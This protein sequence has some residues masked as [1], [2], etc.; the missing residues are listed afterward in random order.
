VLRTY[1]PGSERILEL[2]TR[3]N[4]SRIFAIAPLFERDIFAIASWPGEVV[5]ASLGWQ[6]LVTIS[7]PILMWALAVGVAYFAV[8][9]LALR[10]ILYLDRLVTAYGKSGRA[11]RAQRM[12]D[13]PTEIAKLGV[14]FDEMAEEIETRESALLETVEEKEILLR[15]VNHRVKNNLQLISSLLNLQIRDSGG[16]REKLGLE[17]LQERI[18]GLALVHQKIYESEKMNA[19]RLDRLI[20]EIAGN[21]RDGSARTLDSVK[22]TTALEPVMVAPDVA[23]PLVLFATEAIVNAFKHSLSFA[24][25]GDLDITLK[26]EGEHVRLGVTNSLHPGGC[27]AEDGRRGIGQQLIDGFARQ[28]RGEI[29]RTRTDETF[30]IDLLI[31]TEKVIASQPKAAVS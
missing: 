23:V 27:E 18:Q 9:Q 5:P 7:L 31:P 15:E 29:S 1:L 28:L 17:R 24:E 10:H 11:L 12:R 13:A 6:N 4:K 19:V 16:S 30:S 14:S 26:V 2:P 21:L 20:E 8:D 22:L 3:A 25:S